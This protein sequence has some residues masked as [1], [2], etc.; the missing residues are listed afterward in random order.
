MRSPTGLGAFCAMTLAIAGFLFAPAVNAQAQ[1]PGTPRTAPNTTPAPAA[2]ANI[3]DKKLDAVAAASKQVSAIRGTY[4]PKVAQAPAT[5]KERL[6]GEAN[7][8]MTKA[9]TDQGLSIEE[10]S[11]IVEVAQKDPVV[12]NKLLQRMR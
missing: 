8:A 5:E 1:S 3:S 6:I 9:V 12:R 2:P 11:T 10:Y 7:A 4:E